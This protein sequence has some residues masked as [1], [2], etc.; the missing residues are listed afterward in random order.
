MAQLA[1]PPLQ[2]ALEDAPQLNSI[3]SSLNSSLPL[4]LENEPLLH[5]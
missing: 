5:S 3:G 1:E 2:R 4:A